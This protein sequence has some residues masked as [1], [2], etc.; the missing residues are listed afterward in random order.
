MTVNA[1]NTFN[2]PQKD[3]IG[4]TQKGARCI[5]P[6]APKETGYYL[7]N[8]LFWNENGVITN[9]RV[10]SVKITFTDNTSV[11]YS[12]WANVKKHYQEFFFDER[13]PDYME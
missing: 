11:S 5:G 9:C 6:I 8:E 10:T 12:G 7:F 2:D 13:N 3:E 1:Y 4:N